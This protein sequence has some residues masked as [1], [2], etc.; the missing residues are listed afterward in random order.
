MR[1]STVLS[2]ILLLA[3]ACAGDAVRLTPEQER[4]LDPAL[5]QLVAGGP[6]IERDYEISQG[7]SGET[8]Y[9]IIVRTDH[10]DALRSAGFVV[11]STFADVSVV[12]VTVDQLR[13]LAM[14]TEVLAL[15]NGSHN[16]A[17]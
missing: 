13:R 3:P 17:Q 7:P 1:K 14:M 6:V 15:Q 16:R 11:T 12:R 5:R 9:G 10:P 8:L 2:C 4:K